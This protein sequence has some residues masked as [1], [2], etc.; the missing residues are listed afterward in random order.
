MF[1]LGWFSTGRGLGSKNFLNQ[2]QAEIARG[3][4]DATIEFVFSNREF[5]EEEGSDQFLKLV[6]SY[7]LPLLTLSSRRFRKENGWGP[8]EKHRAA[9]HSEV[10]RQ[11]SEFSPDICVLAGYMLIISKEMCRKL[12][13]INLHPSLP[14]GPVGTW[15]EVIWNLIRHKKRACI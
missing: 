1:K 10:M 11:V 5:G 2:I 9:F 14:K 7:D 8:M 3:Q 13:T 15:K 12:N 6:E 4:L